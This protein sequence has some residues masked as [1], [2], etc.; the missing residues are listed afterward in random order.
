MNLD[1]KMAYRPFRTDLE[2]LIQRVPAGYS[3]ESA[4]EHIQHSLVYLL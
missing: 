3:I 1:A 4:V 2:P